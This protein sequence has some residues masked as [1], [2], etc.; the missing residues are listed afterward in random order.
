MNT[1]EKLKR[2]FGAN[3]KQVKLYFANGKGS[4]IAEMIGGKLYIRSKKGHQI[5]MY[6]LDSQE[7]IDCINLTFVI[8]K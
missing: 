6:N 1:V 5:D 7:D 2:I 4:R 3:K 8:G